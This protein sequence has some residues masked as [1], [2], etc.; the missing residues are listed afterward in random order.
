VRLMHVCLGV[1][2][3][4][5]GVAPRIPKR[6]KPKVGKDA[7]ARALRRAGVELRPHKDGRCGQATV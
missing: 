3:Y 7:V 1:K 2:P 5:R 4:R 6:A